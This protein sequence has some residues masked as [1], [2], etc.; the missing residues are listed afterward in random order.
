MII[1]FNGFVKQIYIICECTTRH[2]LFEQKEIWEDVRHSNL[3]HAGSRKARVCVERDKAQAG[4][5]I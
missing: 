1:F 2:D 3:V 4:N 5:G